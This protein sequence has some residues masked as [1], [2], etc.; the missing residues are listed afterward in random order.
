MFFNYAVLKS[1][2][3]KYQ[4]S[5]GKSYLR[6]KN[7]LVS[8]FNSVFLTSTLSVSHYC[9]ST[10]FVHLHRKIHSIYRPFDEILDI[11]ISQSD[12]YELTHRLSVRILRESRYI[13]S[14]GL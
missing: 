11:Y 2:Y 10:L 13:D 7:E 3:M 9:T 12:K 1:T 14:N 8:K 5:T 6:H 4:L